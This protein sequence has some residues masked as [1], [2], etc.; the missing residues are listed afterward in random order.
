ME[1]GAL[2]DVIRVLGVAKNSDLVPAK[3]LLLRIVSMLSKMCR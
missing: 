2:L 1:C 3:D